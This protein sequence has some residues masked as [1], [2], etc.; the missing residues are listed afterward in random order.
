MKINH[1]TPSQMDARIGAGRAIQALAQLRAMD[2]IVQAR[3][4]GQVTTRT[5]KVVPC[6][7]RKSSKKFLFRG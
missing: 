7:V 5:G 1:P 3:A 6:A 2:T 4:T